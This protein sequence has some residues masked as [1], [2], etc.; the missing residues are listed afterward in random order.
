MS[1]YRIRRTLAN[2]PAGMI[3]EAQLAGIEEMLARI[4]EAA[5][6]AEGK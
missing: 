3:P 2:M 4:H 1:D 5:V 6:A